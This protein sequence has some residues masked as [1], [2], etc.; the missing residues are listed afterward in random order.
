MSSVCP[1]NRGI[2]LGLSSLVLVLS[3]VCL[4]LLTGHN[5]DRELPK[6]SDREYES[7]TFTKI[8][9]VEEQ[10]EAAARQA[11]NLQKEAGQ[12]GEEVG[13]PLDR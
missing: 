1:H 11:A 10:P 5:S 8:I 12:S 13:A 6:R 7:Y 2:V 9:W 3:S 4:L